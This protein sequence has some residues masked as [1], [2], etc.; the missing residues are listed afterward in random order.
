MRSRTLVV[1]IALVATL[2]GAACGG[3]STNVQ[4]D[5]GPP[6]ETAPIV[7]LDMGRYDVVAGPRVVTMFATDDVA[8]VRTE[9]LVDDVVVGESTAEPFSIDWDSTGAADGVRSVRVAAYDAAGNRGDSDPVPV[10]V[11]NA[12]QEAILDEDPDQ[13]PGF[14][15][16]VFSVPASWSGNNEQIDRKYHWSM[17]AGISRVVTVLLFDPAAGFELNFSTGT[18]WCPDSGQAMVEVSE[19]DGEILLE[20]AP[21]AALAE[22]QWFIHV[23]GTNAADM[24]GLSVPFQA[25]VLLFP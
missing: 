7:T 14:F 17:P 23:G 11:A 1:A 10:F 24:K 25:R 19:N 13:A 5:A 12:G 3:G 9:L 4:Q 8:V 18:G 6:D 15:E 22:G 20:H 21:G 2:A 16:S